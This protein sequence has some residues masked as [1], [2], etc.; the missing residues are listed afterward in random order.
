MILFLLLPQ[1]KSLIQKYC[2]YI[3][4]LGK[5][6]SSECMPYK[7]KSMKTT[8]FKDLFLYLRNYLKQYLWMDQN[9][10]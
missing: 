1:K 5:H 9:Q 4:Y 2:A 6:M 8:K 3:N 7:L 10:L